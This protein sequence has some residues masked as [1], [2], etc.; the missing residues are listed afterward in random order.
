MKSFVLGGAALLSVA[1]LSAP[2]LAHTHHPSTAAER[3]K[4]D[5]LNA[6]QLALARGQ[7]PMQQQA[8]ATMPEQN[9]AM[10]ATPQSTAPSEQQNQ[11]N[12]QQPSD[13][14]NPE[15]NGSSPQP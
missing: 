4:T 2:A 9:N 1:G 13:Q 10:T 12:T 11:T 5:D 6:Q 15:T 8:A 14:Q 3:Q 7:Q